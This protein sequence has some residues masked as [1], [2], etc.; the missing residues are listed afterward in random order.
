MA[1]RSVATNQPLLTRYIPDATYVS[2]NV[3]VIAGEHEVRPCPLQFPNRVSVIAERF[4]TPIRSKTI[5]D[6]CGVYY[7]VDNYPQF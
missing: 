3:E 1:S 5:D 6:V 7:T 4:L 2:V